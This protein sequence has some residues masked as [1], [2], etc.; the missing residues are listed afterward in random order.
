MSKLGHYVKG[1]LYGVASAA[2]FTTV[3]VLKPVLG[4]YGKCMGDKSPTKQA[5]KLSK[6]FLD[7]AVDEIK[8]GN[9]DS[10]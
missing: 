7:A 8:E 5:V 3:M 1:T 9:K 10:W 6:C 2:T 4:D